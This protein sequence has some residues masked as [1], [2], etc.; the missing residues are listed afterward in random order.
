MRDLLIAGNGQS[1][2]AARTDEAWIFSRLDGPKASWLSPERLAELRRMLPAIA[3]ARLIDNCWSASGGD[4]LTPED[5]KAAFQDDLKPMTGQEPG[6]IFCAGI[7]LGLTRDSSAVIVLGI[8]QGGRAGCIRLASHKVW[9][10]IGGR[11]INLMDVEQH[12]LNLDVRFSM[13]FCGFDPWQAELLGQR[14]EADT[15]HRRRSQMKLRY[16]TQPWMRAIPAT[17]SN[18]RQIASLTIETFQDRRLQLYPCPLLQRDLLKL[19]CEEKSYGLRL[20]SPRDGEGHGDMFTALSL[21]LL[22]GSELSIK[23]SFAAGCALNYSVDTDTVSGTPGITKFF[24][25]KE[26]YQR[27]MQEVAKAGY[28][29]NGMEGWNEAMKFLGRR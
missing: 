28:D 1:A 23:K 16:S 11:K 19:R 5:I 26:V 14:L 25:E 8:P 29:Y 9:R 17:G 13:E 24:R 18:L 27:R 7:D 4:A 21:A 12:I 2:E 20:V 6:Y 3:A 22:I 10:P 15:A